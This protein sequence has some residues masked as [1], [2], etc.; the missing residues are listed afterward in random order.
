LNPLCSQR[1]NRLLTFLLAVPAWLFIGS[2]VARGEGVVEIIRA[3]HDAAILAQRKTIPEDI[4]LLRGFRATTPPDSW[5]HA[6][7]TQQP[8]PQLVEAMKLVANRLASDGLLQVTAGV[9]HAIGPDAFLQDESAAVGILKQV[10]L[11]VDLLDAFTVGDVSGAKLVRSIA[12]RLAAGA[13][14]GDLTSDLNLAKF[15]FRPSSQ[16]FQL[17]SEAGQ[18]NIDLVRMQVPNGDYWKGQGDGSALDVVRGMSGAL[19]DAR[20]VVSIA[21]DAADALRAEAA[22]WQRGRGAGITILPGPWRPAQWAQ[23]NGKPGT[24][25][26]AAGKREAAT[27]MP[28]YASRGEERSVCDS[29]ETFGIEALAKIGHRLIRSPLLFQGGNVIPVYDPATRQRVLLIGEAEIYRNTALGLT[30]PQ[31]EEAFRVECG[32]DRVVVLPAVSFHIDVELSAREVGG[33]IVVLVNDERGAAFLIVWRSLD[34]IRSLGRI[35]A[36]TVDAA[37]KDLAA[38]NAGALAQ[39]LAGPVGQLR[40]ANGA[41]PEEVAAAF[42]A[43]EV[44]SGVANIARFLLAMDILTGLQLKA[45]ELPADPFARAYIRSLQRRAEDRGRLHAALADLGWR[46]APVASLSDENRGIN[47]VNGFH[48]PRRYLMPAYGG[49]FEAVDQAAAEQIRAALGPM[50][51]VVPVLCGETQRRLGAIHCAA[52][53]YPAE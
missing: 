17:S 5:P 22:K 24:A 50:V 16:G 4:P 1:V 23:D 35:D 53:I 26:T 27:L 20:L 46:V 12:S 10:G 21:S 32:V 19:P 9:I 49:F 18:S 38:G 45:D 51:E 42:S 37:L 43:G 52:S 44:D 6:L 33:R 13:A 11:P 40:D 14:P 8:A 15:A 34:A 41:Y 25:T 29:A 48:V 7:P 28:R 36:A 31:V 39:R 47:Y 2:D 3:D 30:R